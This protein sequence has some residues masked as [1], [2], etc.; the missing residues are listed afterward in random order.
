[1]NVDHRRLALYTTGEGRKGREKR[2]EE[3][4]ICHSTEQSQKDKTTTKADSS[5][6]FEEI[7]ALT[8]PAELSQKD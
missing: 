8:Q 5:R 1:M 3:T 4:L 6:P 7:L 2:Q